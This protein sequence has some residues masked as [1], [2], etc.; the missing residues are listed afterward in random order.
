MYDTGDPFI[1]EYNTIKG[2]LTSLYGQPVDQT[3]WYVTTDQNN[4]SQWGAALKNGDVEFR[5]F[6]NLQKSYI[7]LDMQ[8][9]VGTF[10]SVYISIDYFDKLFYTP[11]Q[12]L[13]SINPKHL[14]LSKKGLFKLN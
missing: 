13:G 8:T 11:L 2:Q 12:A 7:Y 1:A 10:N 3:T 14:S 9:V 6:W 5:C 4:T